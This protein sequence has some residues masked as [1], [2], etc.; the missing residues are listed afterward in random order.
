MHVAGCSYGCCSRF[1]RLQQSTSSCSQP[2][3]WAAS[4]PCSRAAAAA[5][6]TYSIYLYEITPKRF[7]FMVYLISWSP[8]KQLPQTYWICMIL[9]PFQKMFSF[10]LN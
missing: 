3:F 7:D 2:S 6:H 10:N 9:L 1:L 4:A 8:S 5:K